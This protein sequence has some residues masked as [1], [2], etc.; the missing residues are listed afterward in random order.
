M[1]RRLSTAITGYF[2]PGHVEPPKSAPLPATNAAAAP[3]AP[4]KNRRLSSAI[5][6]YFAPGHTKEARAA[7]DYR[8]SRFMTA[9]EI[10]NIPGSPTD[11]NEKGSGSSGSGSLDG[12]P[13]VEYA[14][15]IEMP[16]YTESRP[17]STLFPPGDF[18]NNDKDEL[19]DIRCDVMVNWL[20]QQQ[21]EMLWTAG[22]QDEGVVLKKSRGNYTC[23]PADIMNEPFG[24]FRSIEMLNVK[25]SD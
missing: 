23:C 7:Q 13:T 2:A 10:P 4:E 8:K 6:G 25:V 1:S 9:G 20:Y 5:Q 16:S 14:D 19:R 11:E 18:R 12:S 17:A 22:A 21:M 24:F 15:K 3:P